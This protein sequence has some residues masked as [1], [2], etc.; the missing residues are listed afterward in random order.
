MNEPT[1]LIDY[2]ESIVTSSNGGWRMILGLIVISLLIPIIIKIS[3]T[4]T[5]FLLERKF[6]KTDEKV[7]Q[8]GMAIK[9]KNG[10]QGIMYIGNL[11]QIIKEK[12]DTKAEIFTES[13]S[14]MLVEL[15]PLKIVFM[16]KDYEKESY[17]GFEKIYLPMS[18]GSFSNKR[19]R[20]DTILEL[21]KLKYNVLGA[22]KD[23]KLIISDRGLPLT[24]GFA[25]GY[26]LHKNNNTKLIYE[27]GDNFYKNDKLKRIKFNKPSSQ[28]TNLIFT[29]NENDNV[30][31]L[32]F[33]I[34][35]NNRRLGD[36]I[37]IDYIKNP[38]SKLNP[39][40]VSL[41]MKKPGEIGANFNL[42]RTANYLIKL[43]L[44]YRKQ[45]QKE[46]PQSTIN[47][48]LFY[49]GLFGL[50]LLLGNQMQQT[51]PIQLYEHDGVKQTYQPS[52]KL[53]SKIFK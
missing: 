3:P 41:I 49:G 1:T 13:E 16:H 44:G 20:N 34:E 11:T 45:L 43:M 23:G 26:C 29:N 36:D 18:Y 47:I 17:H 5:K 35:A 53:D 28:P 19:Q 6:P 32:C 50:A 10:R 46:N 12:S 31:D 15:E 30:I 8:N 22:R 21:R 51:F 24:T 42:E 2:T 48:H 7:T 39:C 14:Q 38:E 27:R 52:F 9:I 37:F 40:S 4:L 33:Y 25:I